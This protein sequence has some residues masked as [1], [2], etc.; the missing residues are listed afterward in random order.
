LNAEDCSA[1]QEVA[2]VEKQLSDLQCEQLK[3]KELEL[4]AARNRRLAIED[5]EKAVR[6]LF[7]LTHMLVVPV[8][9]VFLLGWLWSDLFNPGA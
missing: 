1:V 5:L 7:I 3:T 4:K 6:W 9:F 8:A 2:D